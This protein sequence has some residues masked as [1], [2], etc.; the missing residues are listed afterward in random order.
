V[1]RIGLT[2]LAGTI[3]DTIASSQGGQGSL[4]VG[5][6]IVLAGLF[7]LFRYGFTREPLYFNDLNPWKKPLPVWAAR[8]VYI[9]FALFLIYYGIQEFLHA[10]K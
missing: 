6:T 2:N 8:L 1:L 9:P 4:W 3:T 10:W 7:V 5:A